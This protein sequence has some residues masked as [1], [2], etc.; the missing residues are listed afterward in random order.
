MVTSL[1]NHKIVLTHGDFASRNVLVQDTKVV[2]V[3]DWELSGYYPEYLEYV[4]ALW[5]PPWEAGWTKHRAVDQVLKNNVTQLAVV[6]HT[7]DIIL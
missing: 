3:L 4:K 6:W 1:K 5:R 2:T 7:R